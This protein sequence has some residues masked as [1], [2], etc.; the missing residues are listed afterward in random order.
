MRFQRLFKGRLLVGAILALFLAGAPGSAWALS[1]NELLDLMVSEGAITPQKAEKIKVKARRLDQAKK[2]AEEAKR[3]RELRQVKEEAKAE[4]KAEAAKAAQAAVDQKHRDYGLSQISK[5]LKGLH[6]GVL[7]YI[8]YSSG[9]TPRPGD[10]HTGYN[11]FT[12]QRGYLNVT[13]EITPWFYARYTADITQ[14][15]SPDKDAG[16]WEFRTK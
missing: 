9:L 3:A 6:V 14:V 11:Q 13:K 7:A 1:A 10:T 4:A 15:G 5:A 2:A 8:D 12:L 16:D